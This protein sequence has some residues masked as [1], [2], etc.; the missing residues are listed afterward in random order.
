MTQPVTYRTHAALA[1]EQADA[2]TLDNVRDRH[3]RSEAA[4]KAMADRQE[5]LERAKARR[6]EESRQDKLIQENE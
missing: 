1:R 4:F 5:R 6:V 3:L 2:A